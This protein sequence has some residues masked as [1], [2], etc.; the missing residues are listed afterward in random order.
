LTDKTGV[1]VWPNVSLTWVES[2]TKDQVLES[3]PGFGLE[4][5][6]T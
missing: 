1:D 3:V 2:R 4:L 5:K 6:L